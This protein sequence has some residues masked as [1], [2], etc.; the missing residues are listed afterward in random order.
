MTVTI[1]RSGRKFNAKAPHP[2]MVF[3]GDIAAHLSKICMF[4]GAPDVF[5]S[6]AQ[7]GIIVA[8]EIAKIDGP[9]GALY[10]LLHNADR[11]VIC[12]D[13]LTRANVSRVIHEALDLDW[14][15]PEATMRALAQV[16]ARV[17]LSE[18]LQLLRGW[19][20][21]TGPALRAGV[22]PLRSIIKPMTWDRALDRW[23]ETLRGFAL[24]ASI[25]NLP[26]LGDL[27]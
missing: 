24:A 13:E 8:T 18:R 20:E 17:D 23:I 19:T 9:L 14:P 25:P 3:F 22:W 16:E 4:N 5:Y 1:M 7:H 12:S 11:A 21:T 15:A 27:S 10:G 6:A 26:S 2:R